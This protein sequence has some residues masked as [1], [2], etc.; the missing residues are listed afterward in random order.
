MLLMLV[1]SSADGA[2]DL[3]FE[4]I[5]TVNIINNLSANIELNVHCKS[6]D[7]DFGQQQLSYKD[8]LKCVI[9]QWSIQAK[10]PCMLNGTS[11]KYDICFPWNS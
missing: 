10:G 4:K 8:N 5:R 1:M 6:K 11:Q 3:L 2:T 7:D 9:C